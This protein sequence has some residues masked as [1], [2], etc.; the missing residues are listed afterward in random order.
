MAYSI[1]FLN[2]VQGATEGVDIAN[3]A[4]L[5]PKMNQ[6]FRQS[7]HFDDKA[8]SKPKIA[9]TGYVIWKYRNG[10]LYKIE[11]NGLQSGQAYKSGLS[12]RGK[13]MDFELTDEWGYTI[14]NN[15][16]YTPH[17]G[18]RCCHCGMRLTWNGCSRCGKCLCATQGIQDRQQ[19][20]K[21]ADMI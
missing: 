7:Q 11:G 10:N 20:K 12:F 19:R 4:S 21:P 6:H 2:P 5:S 14:P 15:R 16:L 18:E 9:C 13:P 8:I 17:F 3:L 1:A